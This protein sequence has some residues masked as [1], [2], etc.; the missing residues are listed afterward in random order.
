MIEG[1]ESERLN[2]GAHEENSMM[3]TGTEQSDDYA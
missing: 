2:G 1:N 3:L